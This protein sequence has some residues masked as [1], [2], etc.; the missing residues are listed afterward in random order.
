MPEPGE[1]ILYTAVTFSALALAC[2]LLLSAGNDLT[3]D[4]ITG[5]RLLATKKVVQD[6]VPPGADNEVFED[7]IE[8]TAPEYLGTRR[9]VSVYRARQGEQVLAVIFY[10]VIA[11]GYNGPIELA[12]GID[13]DGT[14]SGIRVIEENETK[15]LGSRVHQ[16]ES[17]WIVSFTGK[18]YREIPRERWTLR[19]EDGYFDQISGATITSRGVLNAIRRTL[20]YHATVKDT[21]YE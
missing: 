16:Q 19:T 10:P 5:N 18:S 11:D 9:P 14:L 7:R 20:D 3:R 12:V 1:D 21:L 4:R 13:Q 15:D 17:D 2:F 6:I 8:I